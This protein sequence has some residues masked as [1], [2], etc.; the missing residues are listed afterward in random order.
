M[1]S[2]HFNYEFENKTL[3]AS[4]DGNKDG[5]ASVSVK[6][7]LGE[8]FEE[9]VAKGESKVDAVVTYKNVN[10]KMIMLVDTDRDGEPVIELELDA[11][12]SLEEL[13]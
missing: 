1:T 6:A 10:G 7:N 13:L 4:Y 3:K 8:A 12:E 9:I 2:K 5:E 11:G